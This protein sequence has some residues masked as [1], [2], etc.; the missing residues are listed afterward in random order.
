MREHP[1]A[2]RCAVRRSVNRVQRKAVKDA[3]NAALAWTI[4]KWWGS[5]VGAV[6]RVRC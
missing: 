3:H 2:G 4:A 5:Q 1:S 6:L